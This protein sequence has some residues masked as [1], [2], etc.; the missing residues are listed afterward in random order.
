MEHMYI[1]LGLAAAFGLFMAWGIG[2]NDVANAMAP[3]V[4]S[5][6]SV[7]LPCSPSLVS[8]FCLP[9]ARR[10]AEQG[11]LDLYDDVTDAVDHLVVFLVVRYVDHPEP[12]QVRRLVSRRPRSG[13]EP[14]LRDGGS[15]AR[16]RRVPRFLEAR[17]AAR[18][19]PDHPQ[20]C[21]PTPGKATEP[22]PRRF[23]SSRM[24]PKRVGRS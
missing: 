16:P 14:P 23:A 20:P 13:R 9:W 3:S 2:A 19:R 4:G 12:G 11:R 21:V 15:T 5:K 10:S 8:S 7:R 18:F 24:P 17:P 22:A 6:A 1:Y